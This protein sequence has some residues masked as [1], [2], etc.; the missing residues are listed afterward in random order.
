MVK[1]VKN[2]AWLSTVVFLLFLTLNIFLSQ[3][4]DDPPHYRLQYQESLSQTSD[5]NGVIIGNSKLTHSIRPS[6]LDTLDIKFYNL[7]L[8]GATQHFYFDWYKDL[9]IINHPKVDYWI[10]SADAYFLSGSGREVEKDSEYFPFKYFWNLLIEDNG[11]HKK[12]L[13]ANKIPLLKY[14]SRIKESFNDNT[15]GFYKFLVEDY[16]RGYISLERIDNPV[17]HGSKNVK[18]QITKYNQEK[19]KNLINRLSESD[20]KLVLIIPPEFDLK[21]NLYKNNKEF[22]IKLSLEKNIPLYDFNDKAYS[23]LLNKKENFCDR[24]HLNKKGSMVFSDLLRKE[25]YNNERTII[26]KKH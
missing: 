6:K 11:Y 23:E 7:A 17:F 20:S 24:N 10:I 21:Q 22:L 3:Y 15:Q 9:F 5:Y 26:C 1:F 8:N 4:N 12:D 2:I 25:L 18:L 19:F 14:R 16:D 13:I